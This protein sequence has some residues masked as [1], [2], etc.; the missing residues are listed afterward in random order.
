MVVIGTGAGGAWVCEDRRG[1]GV[2]AAGAVWLAAWWL[3]D[4]PGDVRS[5]RWDKGVAAALP[6]E[7]SVS[8]AKRLCRSPP[9]VVDAREAVA[10]AAG[11]AATAAAIAVEDE[12]GE[13]CGGG[14]CTV[15]MHPVRLSAADKADAPA[16]PADGVIGEPTM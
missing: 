2:P 13:R 7:D 3:V 5:N 15:V 6:W 16:A 11:E 10:D 1:D 9:G 8:G 12:E 14:R 4:G